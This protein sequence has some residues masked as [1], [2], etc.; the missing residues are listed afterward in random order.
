[1]ALAFNF[2]ST[3]QT[4]FITPSNKHWDFYCGTFK[5][6]IF[7]FVSNKLVCGMPLLN[8]S[9]HLR[10]TGGIILSDF[11]GTF[12]ILHVNEGQRFE[13]FGTSKLNRMMA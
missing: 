13:L 12:I 2:P 1:M 7:V 4:G 9:M 3:C 5:G 10:K 11:L 6:N 8:E